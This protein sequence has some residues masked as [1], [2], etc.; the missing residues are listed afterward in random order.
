[1][2]NLWSKSRRAISLLLVM[3]ML[4]SVSPLQVFAEEA[5]TASVTEATE[6]M[7]ET[8]AEP[9][10]E[11]LPEESAEEQAPAEPEEPVTEPVQ[12]EL[13]AET[14][15]P[16]TTPA[17]QP[18]SNEAAD[19]A[20]NVTTPAEES[21]PVEEA[22]AEEQPVEE[23]AEEPAPVEET[24][25]AVQTQTVNGQ[26]GN[27][28]AAVTAELPAGAAVQMS[29][30]ESPLSEGELLSLLGEGEGTE[31]RD[32]QAY[33]IA[34]TAA[35]GSEL[36][37]QDGQTAAVVLSG[38]EISADEGETV[39]AAHLKADGTADMGSV[40]AAAGTATFTVSSFSPFVVVTVGSAETTETVDAEAV[41]QT[42]QLDVQNLSAEEEDQVTLTLEFHNC[43][44]LVHDWKWSHE[45]HTV[46]VTVNSSE[47]DEYWELD[48]AELAN[49]VIGRDVFNTADFWLNGHKQ[50]VV[51][52]DGDSWNAELYV[53]VGSWSKVPGEYPLHYESGDPWNEEVAGGALYQIQNRSTQLAVAYVFKNIEGT[54]TGVLAPAQAMETSVAVNGVA[55]AIFFV[56]APAG[57][58]VSEVSFANGTKGKV[59]PIEELSNKVG[60]Y[61][62]SSEIA[63]AKAEGYTHAFYFSEWAGNESRWFSVEL[64][65]VVYGITYELNGGSLP[66]GTSNPSEYRV[67]DLG[68]GIHL[69]NP[70]RN[71]YKFLGWS[72]KGSSEEPNPDYIIDESF[73]GDL[74]LVA[75]WEAD[76]ATVTFL[77]DNGELLAVLTGVTGEAIS[78]DEY[79]NPVRVG[80]D[81][82]GWHDAQGNLVSTLPQTFP[83]GDT[84]YTAS[85]SVKTNLTYTINYYR[86]SVAE[87]NL[88][89][90]VS[91]TGTFGTTVQY[92][93]A[94]YLPAGYVI[95]SG[96]EGELTIADGEQANVVD[97]VYVRNGALTYTVRYLEDGTGRELA[98]AKTVGGQT[99][100]DSVTVTASDI[101]GYSLMSVNPQTITIGSGENVVTFYYK[102][103]GTENILPIVETPADFTAP[104]APVAGVAVAAA[105]APAAGDEDTAA[106]EEVIEDTE[107]PLAEAPAEEE[108]IEENDTP[109]AGANSTWALLNLLLAAAVVLGGALRIVFLTR[110]RETA[111]SKRIL[112]G[113]ACL[114]PMMGA[115]AAFALTE[116]VTGTMVFADRWTLL[117][118]II[119]AIQAAVVVLSTREEDRSEKADA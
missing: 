56:K 55:A 77:D 82:A 97:V 58:T 119:A 94:Q 87:G 48:A 8:S 43:I 109:L 41:A 73:I 102:E 24:T 29:A 66:A 111:G 108:T 21:Q 89:G 91:G 50:P 23:P 93:A 60:A 12:E 118:V 107:T 100:G 114:I 84:V 92:N 76:T 83:A 96:A 51:S 53:N 95:T 80:H 104:T 1:M 117:M 37:L 49:K 46:Q 42:L 33:D 11:T 7:P 88:L 45:V 13:P 62:F 70:T 112:W 64:D 28:S 86:D 38:L 68:E 9:E 35:D 31:I 32:V 2:Q 61:D 74:T 54:K 81:F 115:A 34:L 17:E 3:A 5:E 110:K 98:S 30:M 106:D 101:P 67:S 47:L 99:Y 27:A 52:G 22:P 63:S 36:S 72:L 39:Y 79:P 71:G 26:A 105:A 10:T 16:E 20:G 78:A 75:N 59:Y 44:N 69:V 65:S 57:Q 116:N 6:T 90:T 85:W 18:E 25:P 4:T 15:E 14:S 113:V 40:D 103:V 19:A